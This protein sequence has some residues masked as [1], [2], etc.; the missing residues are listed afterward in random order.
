[1][2]RIKCTISYDGTS[3]SGYQ[4]QPNKRTVQSEIEA[5]LQKIHKG[6]KVPVTAS[7][8]TDAG[9]HAFG[10]VFHFDT[11]IEINGAGWQRALNANLPDDIYVKAVE[12]VDDNFHA[13][14]DVEKKTYR[15]RVLNATAADVFRRNYVLHYPYSLDVDRMKQ[16]ATILVGTHDFTS[17]CSTRTAV[18][19]K[20]RT[21]YQLDIL[22]EQDEIIFEIS[23]NGF[24]YNM[25][26]I[27]VG[28]LLEIGAGKRQGDELT[29][30]LEKCDRT[31]AGKT[32]PANGLY[33][34]RVV[35]N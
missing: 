18:E 27:I 11:P 3:F 1:M 34:W 29:S 10:Q 23:G 17:F 6:S 33:L 25:V 28:T 14:F 9:V 12:V 21:I 32:A 16:A 24:L 35:Y 8:R 4:V 20:V 5:A 15:Y 26:R 31:L 19:D 30:I 13:R 22:K 7:G 2:R